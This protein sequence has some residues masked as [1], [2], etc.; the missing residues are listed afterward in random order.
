MYFVTFHLWYFCIISTH[1]CS[2]GSSG[3]MDQCKDEDCVVLQ[4]NEEQ[5]SDQSV[6]P[7]GNLDQ[8]GDKEHP[9]QGQEGAG[10]DECDTD[11]ETDSRLM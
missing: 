10:G 11:L 8:E 9:T 5:T 1:W 7:T 4:I 6:Q 3:V 2:A